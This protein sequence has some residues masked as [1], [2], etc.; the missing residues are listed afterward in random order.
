MSLQPAPPRAHRAEPAGPADSAVPVT[1]PA[2]APRRGWWR[3]APLRTRLLLSTMA[4][5]AVVSLVCGSISFLLLRGFLIHQLDGQLG[6]A[7]FRSVALSDKSEQDRDNGGNG[8]NGNGGGNNR[9][10]GGGNNRNNNGNTP[11]NGNNR[12]DG[13]GNGGNN[14][15]DV[16]DGNDAGPRFLR[17][18]GQTVGTIG[19]HLVAGQPT[20][21]G[22]IGQDG[23]VRPL[24]GAAEDAAVAGLPVDGRPHTVL[25]GALG[26]YR[27][28]GLRDTAGQVVI[29]GVPLGEVEAVLAR[30]AVIELVVVGIGLLA[31]GA[32]AT[33]I[34]RITLRPLSRVAVTA[35]RVA[36]LQLERG[37][38]ALAERVP[39]RD[40][41]V[42]TE[43]GQVGAA[44]NRMLEHVSA[45]LEA[46]RASENQLRQFLADASHELRTPLAAIRGYAELARRA[47]PEIPPDTARALRRV[48]SQTERMT[49]LVEDMFLLAR[50]DA[51]RPLVAEP[52][53]L[54]QLVV[55]AV[56]D[57]HAA[58]PSHRWTLHI[59]DQEVLVSG[60][61]TRLAQ[62]LANLLTNAR[63]HTPPGTT[64][65]AALDTSATH[66]ILRVSDDGPGIPAG[67]LPHVFGRFARGDTSRSRE[68]GST[69]LGLAIAHAVTSAHGGTIAVRSRPGET[70]FTVELPRS[71]GPAGPALPAVPDQGRGNPYPAR[72]R[73]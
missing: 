54:S 48:S 28:I 15:N 63:V 16:N 50:L 55:D 6:T 31:A 59:P 2:P 21:I 41:D 64:V 37:D 65:T 10:D 40:T 45:A 32:A 56:S 60:D 66:A 18:P 73:T 24:S 30:L 43:V 11:N 67:L 9:N 7:A 58:G 49:S 33:V 27:L 26:E 22:V 68:A 44:L 61:P 3:S 23:V 71:R 29:T 4:L 69:G 47:G 14:R 53:D 8:N 39:I 72:P 70:V 52:V 36:E 51:G 42:R 1:S 38:V 35:G 46:R 12:N 62:V 57:A 25:V 20:E 17:A 5:L 19:G 13:S 34:V